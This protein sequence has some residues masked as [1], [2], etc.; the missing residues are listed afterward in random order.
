MDAHGVSEGQLSLS[1]AAARCITAFN[2][3]L[4][5]FTTDTRETSLL[6]DELAR[7]SLWTFHINVFVE[8]RASLDHRLREAPDVLGVTLGLLEA[9]EHQV[10]DCKYFLSFV[11]VS[12][13]LH[14]DD[15]ISSTSATLKHVVHVGT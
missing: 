4:Q 10:Q 11:Y 1:E 13:F 7:F 3:C 8:G 2:R 12:L 15:F 9:L 14:T 6:E 5:Q